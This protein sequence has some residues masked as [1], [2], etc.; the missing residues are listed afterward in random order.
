MPAD[1]QALNDSLNDF[2]NII[3]APRIAI[4]QRK[5]ITAEIE[6]KIRD[7]DDLFRFRLDPLVKVLKFSNT[8]FSG[9]YFNTRLI[10]ENSARHSSSENTER[11][12]PRDNRSDDEF[13][14][15]NIA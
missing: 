1:L 9:E 3:V 6:D 14:L 5:Q 7:I 8:R 4:T 11:E 15:G 10:I 13:G 2:R 12:L